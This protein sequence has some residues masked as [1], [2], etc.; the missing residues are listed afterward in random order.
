VFGQHVGRRG[1]SW[2]QRDEDPT[3]APIYVSIIVPAFNEE[4]GIV[5]V[6]SAIRK[7]TVAGYRFEIVVVDDGST[8]RTA[9]LLQ[10]YPDLYDRLVTHPKNSGKG[11]AVISGLKIA[12]GDY[13]LFQDAD[14]EYSPQEYADLFY[15]IQAFGAEIVIGSRF[16]APKYTRVQYFSHKVGNRLI[17]LLFNLL[18]NMTFTDIYTCY[19][20][21]RR[22]LIAPDELISRGWE[23]HAEI[24]CRAVTRARIIYEVPISYHG[25]SYEEGK[26]IRAHNILE[27]LSMIVRCRVA[28]LR[29]RLNG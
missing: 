10:A 20:M 18:Y 3:R 25:R 12:S 19:L 9:A 21:Y 13:V 11:A 28:K 5:A 17:T 4:A 27:V 8:D 26:K 29:D 24:L 22:D 23:Q 16:L 2:M 15:P 14:L 1:L 7:Q 6:L